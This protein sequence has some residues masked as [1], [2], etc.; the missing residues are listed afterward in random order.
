MADLLLGVDGGNTKTEALVARADGT[1]LGFARLLG[2][3]DIYHAPSPEAALDV[4][5]AAADE[6]LAQSGGG[7]GDV[8][9][10][11]FSLAGADWPEDFAFHEAELAHRFPGARFRV[12]NDGIGALYAIVAEGPGVVVAVGTG[13]ATGARGPAGRL[14]HSSFWQEPQ[15]GHELGEAAAHAVY[16]AALGAGPPTSLAPRVLDF[17]GVESVE[18]ALHRHTRRQ[19]GGG[20]VDP[21]AQALLEEAEAGD[22]VAREIVGAHGRAL[23]DYAVAGARMVAIDLA[24]AFPLAMTGGVF[25]H[26]GHVLCDALVARVREDAPAV[27]PLRTDIRPVVGALVLAA[28]V[29]GL[30]AAAFSGAVRASLQRT[31]AAVAAGAGGRG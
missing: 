20:R 22:P 26:A 29:A 28:E 3:A 24:S 14:W 2:C 27:E 16:R 18:E 30:E 1:V 4:I 13:A 10:A 17:F 8:R 7:R 19:G 5:A 31:P 9:A 6:A 11:G 23:G 21:L 25:A 12:T 15:G